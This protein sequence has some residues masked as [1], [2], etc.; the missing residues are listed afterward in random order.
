MRPVRVSG[1]LAF[2]R[3]MG[4]GANR[5][6][7]PEEDLPS[8]SEREHS[9]YYAALKLPSNAD[10]FLNEVKRE[11]HEA[12]AGSHDGLAANESVRILNKRTVAGFRCRLAGTA[13]TVG[14][15][16]RLAIKVRLLERWPMTSLLD[17]FKEADLRSGSRTCSEAPQ[18]GKAWI[19]M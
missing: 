4:Q 7:N 19:G 17:V 6:R 16:N 14:T 3:Y 8:D 10:N 12:L 1:T 18:H 9:T 13:G 5:Y 11:M 2:K 15:W